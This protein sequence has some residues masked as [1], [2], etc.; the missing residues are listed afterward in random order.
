MAA[1]VG[2]VLSGCGFKDGAEVRE[3]VLAL[4]AI[5][6]A[7]GEARCFAPDA[8]QAQVVDHLRGKPVPGETRNVLVEAARIA[9]GKIEDVAHA[10]AT[11]LDALVMPGGF[12]AAKN[13]SNFAEKGHAADVHPEVARLIREMHAAKKP[14]GA[15]CIAPAVVARVLGASRVKVTIGDDAG[16][17]GE[18][19][20]CGAV[21]EDCPV[22]RAV[23][24]RAN[25]VVTTPAYMYGDARLG[26]IADGIDACV[27]EVLAM[28]AEPVPAR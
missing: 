14:I 10:R 22:D 16:T 6:R 5:D 25:R 13:L 9:R 2:V 3:S 7:G 20:A 15:I 23:V 4:L 26:P 18:I 8:P 12:G 28:A 1:R 19:E 27:R 11:D 24:D 21:H 17:A